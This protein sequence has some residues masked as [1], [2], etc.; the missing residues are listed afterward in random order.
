MIRK[1]MVTMNVK[2]PYGMAKHGFFNFPVAHPRHAIIIPTMPTPTTIFPTA[3][4]ASSPGK[5]NA[6]F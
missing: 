2:S 5:L 1:I 6:Y 3:A 4:P